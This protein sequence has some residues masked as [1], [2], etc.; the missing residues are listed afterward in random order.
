MAHRKSDDPGKVNAWRK[1]VSDGVKRAHRRCKAC[2]RSS[3]GG[4]TRFV[5]ERITV[6]RCRYCGH[7]V[8]RSW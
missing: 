2:G 6:W 3:S 1:N 4:S 7:E 8:G 5:E